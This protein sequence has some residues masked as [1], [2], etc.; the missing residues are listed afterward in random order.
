M[1]IL[2][3]YLV[4]MLSLP[5]GQY[6][7]HA[8][9]AKPAKEIVQAAMQA[10]LA[11][12]KNDQTRWRYR[13]AKKDGTDTVSIVVETVYGSVNRVIM[14]NGQPL[15]EAEARA[16][17]E[18]VQR[19]IHDPEKLAK[20]RRDGAQDGKR[21]EELLR[22]L[23]EAF[24]W[25]VAS[26]DEQRYTLHFEPNPNFDPP[27]MQ[28]RVL[29]TMAGTLVVNKAQNRIETISGKLTEDVT[30]GWGLLGRLRE[31]GTFRVERREV[32]PGLWQIVETHVHIEGKALFFK[33]IGEQQDEVQTEFTQVPAGTTLE[34]AAEMSKP[35]NGTANGAGKGARK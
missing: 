31:G 6:T 4:L 13:V 33:T 27:N 11:A 25:K 15:T 14:K 29:G 8:Q 17:D 28:G 23:P 20:Q 30:I 5:V 18:R 1:R 24:T 19:F 26:E 34:Q 32:T 3:S 22:M 21:A 2:K 7:L 10:E 16:E 35:A 9:D 12:G